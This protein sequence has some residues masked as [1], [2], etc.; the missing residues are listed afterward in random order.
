M[1]LHG[2]LTFQTSIIWKSHY[3]KN[4]KNATQKKKRLSN[5]LLKDSAADIEVKQSPFCCL[6]NRFSK[7]K[8]SPNNSSIHLLFT[9]FRDP[10][11]SSNMTAFTV[12]TP[13][14]ASFSHKHSY[15]VN[16]A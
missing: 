13:G 14:D 12:T 11:L 16:K 10:H 9:D 6:E 5:F 7:D 2:I 3:Q 8:N 1:L 15:T 4:R